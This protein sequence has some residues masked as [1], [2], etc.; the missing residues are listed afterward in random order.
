MI[1]IPINPKYLAC[2]EGRIF[3]TYTNKYLSATDNGRG[4]F[5]VKL[6]LHKDDSGKKHYKTMYVHRLVAAAYT[7]NL[8]Q[9][10]QVNHIDG[11][12]SNNAASNLEWCTEAQNTQHAIATKLT[13]LKTTLLPVS[14]SYTVVAMVIESPTVGVLT[15]LK[16][17]YEYKNM[18]TFLRVL[19]GYA[20]QY[21][22]Q[23]EMVCA[24]AL[25]KKASFINR[26]RVQA[27]PVQGKCKITEQ[28]TPVF[29]T[30]SDAAVFCG[31]TAS[32]ILHAINNKTYSKGYYWYAIDNGRPE[33]ECSENKVG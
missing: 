2:D 15:A 8:M 28:W 11:D 16:A 10:P 18:S 7:P 4:Y 25:Y 17:K 3:S 30:L 32:N 12:K 29:E 21:S 22:L 19:R 6:Y 26:A 27:K 1:P 14:E 24:L 33:P 23:T 31:A 13:T 5:N 9:L 20:E